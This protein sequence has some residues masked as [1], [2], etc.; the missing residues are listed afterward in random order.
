[1]PKST[2]DELEAFYNQKPNGVLG[3][4]YPSL[5]NKIALTAWTGDPAKYYRNH[6]YGVGHIAVCSSFDQKAFDA[7]RSAYVGKGPE[8]IPLS[9]DAPGMGPQ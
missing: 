7:F 1:M 6:Y 5:G 9:N 8:G 3:T 4:L 2:V